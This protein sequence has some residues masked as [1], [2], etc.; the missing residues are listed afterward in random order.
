MC[1]WLQAY[2]ISEPTFRL[3][4]RTFQ[5]VFP[6][7]S[8]WYTAGNDILLIG[9]KKPLALDFRALRERIGAEPVCDDLRGIGI[10]DAESFLA[11]F[12]AQDRSV[13]EFAGTRRNSLLHTDDNARLEF[14]MPREMFCDP[15]ALFQSIEGILETPVKT[16]KTEGS[17]GSLIEHLVAFFPRVDPLRR[18]QY[19][20]WHVNQA[21]NLFRAGETTQALGR[22]DTALDWAGDEPA[23]VLGVFE[24]LCAQARKMVA[25]GEAESAKE[26]FKRLEKLVP[27]V[28][29]LKGAGATSAK[30]VEKALRDDQSVRSSDVQSPPSHDGHEAP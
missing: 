25:R 4:V 9:S 12:V 19:T 24:F 2:Q 20:F 7:C 29:A 13:A 30:R 6:H 18:C 10:W 8:L 22:L 1:Q 26:C 28:E 27:A 17:S 23:A 11:H 16:I 15:Q 14:D 21:Q 5:H 3:V